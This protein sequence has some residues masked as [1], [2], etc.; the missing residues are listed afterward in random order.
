MNGAECTMSVDEWVQMSGGNKTTCLEHFIGILKINTYKTILFC[1]FKQG[2]IA[3]CKKGQLI[4][5]WVK[6]EPKVAAS[7]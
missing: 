7:A 3:S 4:E 1:G 2:T 5:V 6:G